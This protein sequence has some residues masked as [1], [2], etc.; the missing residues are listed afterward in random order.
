MS[1]DNTTTSATTP[2]TPKVT[3]LTTSSEPTA[4][5]T[6]TT[7][8]LVSEATADTSSSAVAGTVTDTNQVQ[9]EVQTEAKTLET[10]VEMTIRVN[11]SLSEVPKKYQRFRH[12]SHHHRLFVGFGMDGHRCDNTVCNRDLKR[13]DT[14]FFCQRCDYDLCAH[15]FA[16]APATEV[17]LDASDND[18]DDN[19]MPELF[20]VTLNHSKYCDCC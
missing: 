5:N 14:R 7:V 6:T 20:T 19:I 10:C 13:V 16:F 8:K 4:E 17:E 1:D 11:K 9:A 12:G 3:E 15:C 2:T 18:V